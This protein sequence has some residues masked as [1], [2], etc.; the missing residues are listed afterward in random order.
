MFYYYYVYMICNF[1]INLINYCNVLD[2]LLYL[3]TLDSNTENKSY[4]YNLFLIC[5]VCCCMH[6]YN[7]LIQTLQSLGPNA[8]SFLLSDSHLAVL[9]MINVTAV[10]I[11]HSDVV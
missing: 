10:E 11:L 4:A 7:A 8:V 5:V 3:L 1:F 6:Q 9:R 2:Y